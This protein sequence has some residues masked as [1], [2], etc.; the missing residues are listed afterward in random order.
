MKD[1]PVVSLTDDQ[2]KQL[3]EVDSTFKARIAE[4]ELFLNGEMQKAKSEF[5]AA[6]NEMYH[7]QFTTAEI[8]AELDLAKVQWGFIET[9]IAAQPAAEPDQILRLRNVATTSER[10]LAVMDHVTQMYEKTLR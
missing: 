1:Q 7:S 6:L 8:K 2:K 10:I 3:A 5:E 4:K 9:A